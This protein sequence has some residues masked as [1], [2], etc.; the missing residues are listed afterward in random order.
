M[1]FTCDCELTIKGGTPE[2]R[3][4]AAAVVFAADCVEHG[5]TAR[6]ERADSL[7]LR[8]ASVDGLPEDEL[9][10]AAPQFPGL[11]F[12]LVYFSKDGEFHG[13]A[14]AGTEGDKA[15]SE[16]LD[17]AALEK[18]ASVHDGDGIALA[19]AAYGLPDAKR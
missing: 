5:E 17:E 2:D 14:R 9:A 4:A 11:G 6:R 10:V 3:R 19:R 8:F 18:L 16:D 13:Y 1:S 15:E 12:I 7:L